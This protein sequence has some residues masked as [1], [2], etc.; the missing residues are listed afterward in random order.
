[1]LGL[2]PSSHRVAGRQPTRELTSCARNLR[3]AS[4]IVY[5]FDCVCLVKSRAIYYEI[6]KREKYEDSDERANSDLTI[7]KT[8]RLY[9]FDDEPFIHLFHSVRFDLDRPYE[10]P[11]ESLLAL[12]RRDTPKKGDP[13][14]QGSGILNRPWE[15]RHKSIK[16]SKPDTINLEGARPLKSWELI[17]PSEGSMCKGGEVEG[18]RAVEDIPSRVD[19][20]KG[21]KEEEEEEEPE[22]DPFEEKMPTIPRAMDVDADEDYLQYLE[23]L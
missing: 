16:K 2:V 11:I 3:K 22:E 17:P 10:L 9:Q 12:R 15:R 4:Y 1:M 23:E 19:D 18:K 7:V 20:A 8:R 21:S 14:P 5:A 13:S 6:E